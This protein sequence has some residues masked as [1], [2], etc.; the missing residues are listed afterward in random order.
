MTEQPKMECTCNQC[1]A[2]FWPKAKKDVCYA[3]ASTNLIWLFESLKQHALKGLML[4][5]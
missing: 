3:C 1:G 5:Y 2:R 4:D